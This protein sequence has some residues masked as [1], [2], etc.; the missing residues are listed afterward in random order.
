[1]QRTSTLLEQIGQERK[2]SEEQIDHDIET[3]ENNRLYY[4]CGL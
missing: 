3:M 2:W 4:V 1:M